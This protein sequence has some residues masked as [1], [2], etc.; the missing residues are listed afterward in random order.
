MKNSTKFRRLLEPMQL[1]NVRMKNRIVKP[2]QR[3]GF[4][5]K[6]YNITQQGVDFYEAIAKG[7]VGLIIVDHSFVDFPMGVKIRQI[8]IADDS[9]IPSLKILTE[10]VHRH[11]C[12]VFVQI[13]HVGPEHDVK[14]S[15]GR[16]PLA[17]SSL[18]PEEIKELYP[19]DTLVHMTKTQ[20]L[21]IPE[22]EQLVIKFADAAE[23]ARKAGFDGV[24]IHGAHTYLVAAFLSRIW[25]KRD[26]K[27][28]SQ[29]LENRA[30]FATEILQAIRARVGKDFVVGIRLN[31]G[32]YGV[33]VGNTA[34][35]GKEFAKMMQAAGADYINV[36]AWGYA[37]Y[38]RINLPEQVF[39][40]EPP[41]PFSPELRFSPSGTMMPLAAGIKQVVTIPV[42]AAGRIDPVLGEYML[43]KHMADAICMGR[44]ILSDPELPNKIASGR[45]EDIAPCTTCIT[46]S[47][48]TR[49]AADVRCRINAALGHEREY[50]IKPAAKKKKVVVVG[51]G[52]AGMEAARVAALRG[53]D[54]TLYEK[55][56][57]LGG[58]L[59]LAAL[60]KG[61][62][63]ENI[64]AIPRYL[65][66]QIRNGGVKINLGTK[67]TPQ[68]ARELKPDVVILANG[69][70]P[71][72]PQIPGIKGKNVMTTE[73]LK[74]RSEFFLNL[75]G[76]KFLGWATKFYL[77][78]GKN[79]VIVGG[80][81]Y[82]LE[83]AEFL[84]KRGRKVTIVEETDK[85]GTGILESHLPKLLAWLNKKGAKM[86]TGAKFE[87]ITA[88][89]LVIS[90]NG[91][92]Q[93]LKADTVLITLPPKPNLEFL[94]ELKSIVP[95]VYQIGDGKEPRLIVDAISDAAK[96][97]RAV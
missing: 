44:K 68:A 5:D 40:P 1:K 64:P 73:N 47:E 31:G 65:E 42:F 76:P 49:G 14:A 22:I 52:P 74:H 17:P 38:Q 6:D 61:T 88:Q 77:P 8:S 53:H 57:K 23:R 16:T 82:G 79:V 92:K 19:G 55:G 30:R 12:P 18:S 63:I 33:K 83:A 54:V 96:I 80:L 48:T 41:E 69:A 85:L 25:N 43:S 9:H 26:D 51:G 3:L 90:T 67:F 94:E 20:A 21:T 46:C 36:T 13:G 91:Q 86:I 11:N 78:V 10:A 32:E 58:V 34:A 81:I 28:G 50:E 97:G 56:S 72:T 93:L 4:V 62:E 59:P 75:F 84:I 89:G 71:A 39:Y 29:S 24:E 45:Y 70:V 7:G 2:P 35:E 87:E 60:I 37:D 66:R 95:E 27:Y 15:G